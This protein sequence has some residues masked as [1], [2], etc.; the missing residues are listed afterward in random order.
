[1]PKP[2]CSRASLISLLHL[3]KS[4]TLALEKLACNKEL[5][6]LQGGKKRRTFVWLYENLSGVMPAGGGK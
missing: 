6:P 5:A 3:N 4:E 2:A 1:M